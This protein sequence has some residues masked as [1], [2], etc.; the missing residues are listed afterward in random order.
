MKY[1]KFCKEGNSVKKK[2]G[3]KCNFFQGELCYFLLFKNW[4]LC[5][6]IYKGCLTLSPILKFNRV[7]SEDGNTTTGVVISLFHSLMNISGGIK[8]MTIVKL[9]EERPIWCQYRGWWV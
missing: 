8:L 1:R 7:N 5:H 9:L 2:K 6:F 3:K 4:L